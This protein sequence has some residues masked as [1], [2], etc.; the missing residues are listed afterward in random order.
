MI[1]WRLMGGVSLLLWL[2]M[3]VASVY[4]NA[5]ERESR[6]DSSA[7]QTMQV[8][9]LKVPP[10]AWRKIQLLDFK[11]TELKDIVRSLGTKYNLNIFVED[12]IRQRVTIRLAEISVHEAL[13]FLA[14]E[15]GLRLHLENSIYK[16]TKPEPPRPQPKPLKVVYEN[17]LLSVDVQDEALGKVVRAV[18]E[19][20]GKSIVLHQGVE[21]KL[22]GYL[23]NVPFEDGLHALLTS[24]GF[25][26]R[27]KEGIYYVSRR[28]L[29]RGKSGKSS[30]SS[31]WMSVKDSLITLDVT[32]AELR[33][34]VRELAIQTGVDIFIYGALEGKINAQCSNIPFARALEYLF[35]G[36]NYTY[37]REGSVYFIG[38]KNVSGIAS[39]KLIRLN[40]MKVDGILDLLPS[41]IAKKATLNI[42]K[43]QNGLLVVGAQDAIR[44][45]VNFISEIDHPIAQIFLEA[46]VVDY[47]ST[48][49]GEFGLTAGL[50]AGSD[51]LSGGASLFPSIDISGAATDINKSLSFYGP[52]FGIKNIGKLPA[53]FFIRLRALER[54]GKAN[55]RSQP[56]IATLNGHP[57]SIRIGTTQYYILESQQPIVGGNQILNQVT[58]RF[59]QITAEISLTITPW[60]SAS[61]EITTEIHPEFSTPAGKFD[62]NLPPAINHRILD[63]T[64]RLRDGETIVLGGLVQ[65]IDSENIDKVPILGSIPLLG[66]VFQNRSH[67]RTK[68]ELIIYV[69]PHLSYA[70]Q[71]YPAVEGILQ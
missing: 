24:N 59:E 18:A 69:T 43:E 4:L 1:R 57:A 41:E 48:D 6:H 37:R 65:W 27:K 67:N 2:I 10:N 30:G 64:V 25:M 28:E 38:N 12:K 39:M 7:V 11:S 54:E 44:E 17:A 19:K 46:I 71:T 55:I 47:N 40:H 23:Q 66:R 62:P 5:Q 32:D 22:S 35:K 58:Q 50:L 52:I 61:G 63:S 56:Q 31:F 33:H 51:S 70:E 13:R 42:V 3:F 45:V 29:P 34:I 21:G 15:N 68:S 9:S 20:S 16:I 36:T 49:I 60:V 14:R 8:D 26:L 53:D